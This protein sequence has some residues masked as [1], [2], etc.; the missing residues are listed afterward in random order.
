MGFLD[1]ASKLLDEHDAR[2]DEAIERAGDVVDQQ[3]GDS[4]ADQVDKVQDVAREQTGSGD[5][6]G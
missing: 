3:T 5:T 2:V 4:Y 1:D 6:A